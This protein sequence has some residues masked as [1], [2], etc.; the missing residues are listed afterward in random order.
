MAASTRP[1]RRALAAPRRGLAAFFHG[2]A[3]SFRGA[4]LVYLE[5]SGLAVYWLVPILVTA[6]ALGASVAAV[7]TYADAIT[8]WLWTPPSGEG[9]EADL[10][11]A[12]YVVFELLVTIVLAA[13]AFVLTLLLSSVVSAPFNG[14]LA[15]I[16]DERITGQTAPPFAI[17]RVLRD[18]GRVLVIE[19]AFFALNA[20]LVIVSLVAPVLGPVTGPL[21]L[22]LAA[23]YFGISYLETPQATRGRTLGERIAL[24]RARPMEIV[25]FGAGVGLFLF[26]PL[27]NLLFMPA[28]VAGGVLLHAE[29]EPQK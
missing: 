8:A 13:L 20:V 23:L 1:V 17:G 9:W 5:Q 26:V 21:G 24:V 10:A 18:V 3:F 27:V 15:E 4:R 16:L 29:L 6:L 7:V 22:V 25:G 19:T 11:R 14:R 2:L 12:I 28:A